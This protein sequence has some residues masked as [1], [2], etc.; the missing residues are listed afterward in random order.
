MGLSKGHKCG[1]LCRGDRQALV[2]AKAFKLEM[3]DE[4]K[5]G[6]PYGTGT[7]SRIPRPGGGGGGEPIPAPGGPGGVPHYLKPIPLNTRDIVQVMRGHLDATEPKLQRWLY[8][9]W[10]ASAS[11]IKDQEIRNAIRD[12]QMHPDWLARWQ[13]D[14]TKYVNE[15]LA[16]QWERTMITSSGHIASQ[17][18]TNA[19]VRLEFGAQAANV[20]NWIRYRGAEHIVNMTTSQFHAIR[21]ILEHHLIRDPIPPA[22]LARLIRPTIGLTPRQA[23]AVTNYRASLVRQEL[24]IKRVEHLTGNYTGYLRRV[25]AKRIARTETA[26]AY[27]NG[28]L[29]TMRQNLDSGQ[30]QGTVTKQY[31]TAVDER[32][33]EF[34]GP[35]HLEI[36]GLEETFPGA[37][38]KLPNLFV[39]PVHPGCRCTVIYGLIK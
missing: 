13:Q 22:Q 24:P 9:T 33:C 20:Q 8:S 7:P 12:G 29:E 37:T 28:M 4:F 30:L 5:G 25:R 36:I 3:P 32:V 21:H 17:A 27:N 31:W 18:A 10:N 14:Y 16:P 15:R 23:R 1:A 38:K 35:L 11:A 19:G 39:P 26:F 2:D 6:D 34:C